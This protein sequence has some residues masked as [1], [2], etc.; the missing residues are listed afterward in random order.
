MTE[1]GYLTTGSSGYPE[2]T[3]EEMAQEALGLVEELATKLGAA[4]GLLEAGYAQFAQALLDVQKN[5]YWQNEFESWGAYF[6]HVCEKFKL[7]SR[8]LYHKVATVKELDGVVDLSA[9]TEMG[10]T[11]AS[12]LAK[13]V[14]GFGTLP[15]GII[16]QAK[17][18]ETTAKEL[19]KAIAE[20][21]HQPEI[22]DDDWLDLEYA[23][24]VTPEEREEIREAE[25]IARAI[26]PPI[27]NS[28]KDFQQRKE[29]LIRF[30]R[31]FLATYAAPEDDNS[32]DSQ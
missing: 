28:L 14:R 21:L 16:E 4:E 25:K 18:P 17:N 23:F 15:E 24:Y 11:K 30:V 22:P 32:L 8:Q 9:L 19:K 1:P 26:D 12:V 13:T 20:A 7:G 2:V 29:V 6:A 3:E 27:S 31:E 10:I 5:R